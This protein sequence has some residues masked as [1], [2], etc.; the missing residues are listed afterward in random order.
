MCNAAGRAAPAPAVQV[1]SSAPKPPCCPAKM[2]VF[3]QNLLLGL[4]LSQLMPQWLSSEAYGTWAHV[5]KICTMFCLSY[6]MIH[7]G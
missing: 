7:V 3:T 2:I 5:V 6:I 1:L 4:L